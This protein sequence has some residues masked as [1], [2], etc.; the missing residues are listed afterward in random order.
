MFNSLLQFD[1][2]QKQLECID[3]TNTS[4]T[5]FDE[6]RYQ[7][8]LTTKEEEIII[9]TGNY[10]IIEVVK[11]FQM[12]KKIRKS[13]NKKKEVN[14]WINLTSERYLRYT[15]FL[16]DSND[17]FPEICK[18]VSIINRFFHD[19][20]LSITNM[21]KLVYKTDKQLIKLFKKWELVE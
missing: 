9:L 17:D 18:N 21:T 8:N 16:T 14:Q 19:K 6:M 4:L 11:G 2:M 15:E 12:T 1:E 20:T 10:E 5:Q 13:V 7:L 3:D